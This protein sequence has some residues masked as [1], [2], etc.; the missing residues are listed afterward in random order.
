[1]RERVYAT[2]L[3]RAEHV[4]RSGRGVILDATFRGRSERAAALALGRRLG[5]EVLFVECRCPRALALERLSK[6]V[7]GQSVSDAREDLYDTF[8][9][10]YEPMTELAAAQHMIV[11]THE[12]HAR[13]LE[14]LRPRLG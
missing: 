11:D 14:A 6:R 8:A 5:M 10:H 12:P 4:L 2:L 1:M 3:T 13:N 9:A 7:D